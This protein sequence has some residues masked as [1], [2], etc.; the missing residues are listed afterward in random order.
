MTALTLMVTLSLVIVSWGGTSCVT[1]RKSTF[2]MRSMNGISMRSPGAFRFSLAT[3]PSRNNTPRSY[4]LTIRID[5]RTMMSIANTTKP[6]E[7]PHCINSSMLSLL[8][9]PDQE[10]RGFSGDG[11][12]FDD[13]TQVD[14]RVL[15]IRSPAGAVYEDLSV[16]LGSPVAGGDA[17][18]AP[19]T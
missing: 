4:S 8:D 13:V 9:A 18:L 3:R 2:T 10:A 17:Y 14:L 5:L 12:H 19:A 16:A 6:N 11:D 1:V 7:P 15:G